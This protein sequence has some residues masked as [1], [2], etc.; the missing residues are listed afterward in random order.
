MYARAANPYG[1]SFSEPLFREI[2]QA[3]IF[4]A[5]T[6]FSNSGRLNLTG[7]GAATVINGQ[8]V[9]GSSSAR[10][11][12]K[13]PRAGFGG[14]GR[15]AFGRTCCRAELWLLAERFRGSRYVIG[16][17]IEL[18]NV[19][20]RLSHHRAAVHRNYSGERLRCLAAAVRRATHH[21]SNVLAKPL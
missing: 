4:S 9:S 15:Q 20:S 21:R 11:D 7:N 17:T 14:S 8:L 10:W 12:L 2:A 1:C 5:T 19:P 3:N 6:A 13:P 18:N 16:R